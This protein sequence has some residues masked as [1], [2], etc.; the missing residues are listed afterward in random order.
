M[1]ENS[2]EPVAEQADNLRRRC[3]LVLIPGYAIIDFLFCPLI[4]G[5]DHEPWVFVAV[6]TGALIG[7]VIFLAIWAALGP[8]RLWV[9]WS[10]VLLTGFGLYF[11]VILGALAAFSYRAGSEEPGQMAAASLVIPL[12]FLVVQFPLWVRRWLS[13]WRIVPTGEAAE[14]SAVEARQF[15]L[16]HILGLMVVLALTLSLARFFFASLDPLDRGQI[17]LEV[18]MQ[19]GLGLG[20]L[21]VYCVVWAGPALRACFLAQDKGSGC[22]ALL[23][24]WIG[25][26]LV[27]VLIFATIG[28]VLGKHALPGEFIASVFLHFGGI[29]VVL[30]V[31]LHLLGTFGYT[32]IR[33]TKRRLPSQNTPPADTTVE[34]TSAEVEEDPEDA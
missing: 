33:T 1:E 6:W 27:T 5:L 17:P 11:S 34:G 2:T 16:V 24:Y 19:F 18:W 10:L 12:F 9:R 32:M 23:G 21:C 31:S 13:G 26:S 14:Y 28:V 3:F 4:S 25:V 20:S 30:F 15:G 22:A 29:L 8:F 7:Q